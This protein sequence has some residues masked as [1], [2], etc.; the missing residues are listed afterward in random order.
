MISHEGRQMMLRENRC[1]YGMDSPF[2][3]IQVG[4]SGIRVVSHFLFWNPIVHDIWE[5]RLHH[6]RTSICKYT[7]SMW[8][9][10]SNPPVWRSKPLHS[11]VCRQRSLVHCYYTKMTIYIILVY[12]YEGKRYSNIGCEV[13]KPYSNNI[14][15]VIVGRFILS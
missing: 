8:Y 10:P 12:K 7:Q 5:A 15:S 11:Y 4:C 2:L 13:I 9:F 1:A 3:N 14:K 6:N